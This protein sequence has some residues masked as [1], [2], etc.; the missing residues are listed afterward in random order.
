MST[1]AKHRSPL[2]PALDLLGLLGLLAVSAC[3]EGIDP[4]GPQEVIEIKGGTFAMG[5]GTAAGSGSFDPC[6]AS[7][8]SDVFTFVCGD[9]AQ[10]EL[11]R[12]HV[13]LKTFFL[14]KLEVT[15]FRYRHCEAL[16]DCDGPEATESGDPKK[17]EGHH[18]S[19]YTKDAFKDY[20]VIGVTAEQAEKYCK[21]H[22]GRLP[23]EA[24]W[25]FAA[26]DGGAE[27]QAAIRD[28]ETGDFAFGTCSGKDVL[29]AGSA[30]EDETK[31]GVRD[32]LAS[33]QEWVA[34]PFD[35][36]AYCKASSTGGYKDAKPGKFPKFEGNVPP[37]D[38]A[39]PPECLEA[40]GSMTAEF[41]GQ[42][43][44]QRLTD[45]AGQCGRSWKTSTNRTTAQATADFAD[46][47]CRA[48]V[49]EPPEG[50][51]CSKADAAACEAV[52]GDAEKV[53]CAHFCSCLTDLAAH[54]G[55]DGGDCLHE[56]MDAYV[57]CATVG[58]QQDYEP[59]R[60]ACVDPAA[61]FACVDTQPNENESAKNRMRP[62]C[63]PRGTQAAPFKGYEGSKNVPI[64]GSEAG[65]LEGRHTI[66]GANFSESEAC[67]A[68]VT[69]RE[70]WQDVAY[71][72]LV[73][74]RCAYDSK[75]AAH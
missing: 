12:N 34:D 57:G 30:T 52:V 2:T 21:A 31:A 59:I 46:S 64:S 38:V 11:T 39:G 27:L 45:C 72:G 16:G 6:N 50:T 19:Y 58:L 73:G 35:Y 67:V 53:T 70:T 14:D 62:I 18:K 47:L 22:G 55:T 13:E 41:A 61:G 25:E 68:R 48:R 15:N 37:T 43:C 20:P 33:V 36:L 3:A 75:P 8:V 23:T 74:F 17:P 26:Q 10:S 7:K 4:P 66:R 40:E 5:A 60:T 9:K 42:G 32:M 63:L 65:T 24:E 69:R 28:C 49:S 29:E 54:A 56:C 71:S 44:N 1:N 51:D